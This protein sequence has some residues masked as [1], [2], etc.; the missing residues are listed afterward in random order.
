M[1]LGCRARRRPAPLRHTDGVSPFG[2]FKKQPHASV[3]PT[4]WSLRRE[5]GDVVV[6]IDDKETRFSQ[7]PARTIRLVPLGGG[8]YAPNAPRGSGWQVA[9]HRDD[10]DILV[11]PPIP[12]AQAAIAFARRLA[13][14][15]EI[16]LDELSERM[17]A[18]TSPF[19]PRGERG[20]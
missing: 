15:A 17:F 18:D 3:D 19:A 20:E 1:I 5:G 7:R 10:G 8:H 11:G 14:T 9:V 2:W 13:E 16:R 6:G 12:D 4:V